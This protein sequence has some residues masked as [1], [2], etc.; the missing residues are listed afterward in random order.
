MPFGALLE[1]AKDEGRDFLRTEQLSIEVD[2][3]RLAVSRHNVIGKVGEIF[4][5]VVDAQPHQSLHRID[6][7]LWILDGMP[8]RFPTDRHFSIRRKAEHRG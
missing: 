5:Q 1:L 7:V 8:A 3:D 2:L 6:G 4:F